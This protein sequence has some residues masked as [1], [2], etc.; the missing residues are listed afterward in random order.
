MG[1]RRPWFNCVSSCDGAYN[2]W[3]FVPSVR[4]TTHNA[5][6]QIWQEHTVATSPAQT[7]AVNQI[8]L[9]N[10]WVYLTNILLC[11]NNNNSGLGGFVRLNDGT[12]EPNGTQEVGV[13]NARFCIGPAGSGC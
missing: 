5:V 10:A 12:G 9:F 2:L 11:G 1:I 6:Y 8:V 4:A 13:D 7:V 3:V